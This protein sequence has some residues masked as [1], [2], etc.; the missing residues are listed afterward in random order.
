[1]TNQEFLQRVN[2]FA[3]L[4]DRYLKALAKA[5]RERKYHSGE[6]ILRQGEQGIGMY[7]I[8]SGAVR[9]F[10]EGEDGSTYEIARHG[11]GEVVG[12]MAVLDGALRSAN[13]AAVEDT[14]CLILPSWDF[15]SFMQSHPKVA[16][17]ILPIVVRR[18][19]ETNEALIGLKQ[20]Q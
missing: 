17:Q 4:S 16:L 9:V 20:K 7:I 10:K 6:Y 18:F 15:N 14:T 1:M 8:V 2:L 5:C 19:R 13:V 3:G 12:E 11:S